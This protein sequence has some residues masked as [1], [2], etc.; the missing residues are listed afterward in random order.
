MQK[1]LRELSDAIGLGDAI[2]ICRKW[3]GREIR[4]PVKVDAGDPLAL[5]LGLETARKLV[6]AYG[7]QRLQLPNERNAL[8]D[9]RNE[10]VWQACVVD[11]RPAASVALE[12]GLTRQGVLYV[13]RRMREQRGVKP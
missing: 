4:V 13:L 8:L 11:G 7:D 1:V 9:M 2:A 10:A 6:V 3:G 12:Y 5:V